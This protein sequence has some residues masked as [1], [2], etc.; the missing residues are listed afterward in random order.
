MSKYTDEKNKLLEEV[1]GDRNKRKR[2]DLNGEAKDIMIGQE[3]LNRLINKN[4]DEINKLS[5]ENGM[6][7]NDFEMLQKEINKGLRHQG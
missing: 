5:K 3:E 4:M 6:T 2:I 1:L 7:D